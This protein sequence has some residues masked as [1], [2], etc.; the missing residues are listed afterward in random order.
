MIGREKLPALHVRRHRLE[1]QVVFL[2]LVLMPRWVEWGLAAWSGDTLKEEGQKLP[3]RKFSECGP[4]LRLWHGWGQ[5]PRTVTLH[6]NCSV[7][8]GAEPTCHGMTLPY[9]RAS[10]SKTVLQEEEV[11]ATE[12]FSIVLFHCPY[13]DTLLATPPFP[14]VSFLPRTL[15]SAEIKSGCMLRTHKEL[16]LGSSAESWALTLP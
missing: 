3:R 11:R 15:G 13:G 16:K 6:S 4:V 2:P 8:V 5:P 7:I 14:C 1:S 10:Q 12:I 9:S